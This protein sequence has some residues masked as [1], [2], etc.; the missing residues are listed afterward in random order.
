MKE[1]TRQITISEKHI[2]KLFDMLVKDP[3][4]VLTMPKACQELAKMR[5]EDLNLKE[6]NT[7]RLEGNDVHKHTLEHNSSNLLTGEALQRPLWLIRPLCSIEHIRLNIINLKV[8][9]IGPRSEAE[10]FHLYGMGFK[11][12]NVYAVDL[13]SYSPLIQIGDMHNLLYED[14]SFDVVIVGWVFAYSADNQKAA[15][16]ILRVAKHDAHIAVGCV[17]EPYS[18]LD[19]RHDELLEAIGGIPFTSEDPS[20]GEKTV[21]RYFH[22]DQIIGLFNEYID[23]VIFCHNRHPKYLN[24]R[25]N[26]M[27]IFRLVGNGDG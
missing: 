14:N 17:A 19:D 26:A 8:L 3:G 7:L 24:T 23:E 25:T 5:L 11:P 1:E 6:I 10:L 21:S 20:L 15:N 22:T 18:L 4:L 2:R 12:E 13:M 9:T 27:I 16:E